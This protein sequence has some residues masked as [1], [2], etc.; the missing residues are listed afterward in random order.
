MIIRK[1]L[2]SDKSDIRSIHTKAF[3]QEKGPE[4]A[5]LALDLL[6]D[7]TAM[8]LLSLVAEEKGQ[9]LGHI[10]FTKSTLSTD[11]SVSVQLLAP[12]A[13]LPEAQNKG[14]GAALIH[15]GLEELKKRKVALV[16]VLGHPGYYPKCGFHPVGNFKYNAPY[17]IPKEHADA[18]MVQEL[19]QETLAKYAG[20]VLCSDV[21]NQPQH[22][23]E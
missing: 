21:L 15:A 8:P 4:I 2:E 16:F 23:R 6:E 13:I 7:Q 1:S 14:V 5:D 18:W 12:L 17:P 3:G 20:T 11:S 10:L 9:L 19:I 22:W